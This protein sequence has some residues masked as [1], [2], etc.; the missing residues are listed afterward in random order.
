M[1]GIRCL[2]AACLT[3]LTPLT[4]LLPAADIQPIPDK[5]V[6]LTFDDSVRSHF[7]VARPILK[8][9]GFGATFFITEGFDFKTNKQDYLT[10]KQIAQL[11]RDGFEIGNHTRDHLGINDNNIDQLDEQLTAINKQCRLHGITPPVSFAYPGNSITTQALPILAKH[12]FR[13]ARRG[14]T[15]EYPYRAGRGSAY[16]PGLDHP[17]LIPTAGDARPDWTLEDFQRA[18]EQAQFGRIAVLQF[19]GVP[20][21]SHPWV[22]TSRQKFESYMKYLALNKYQVI[23]LRDLEKYVPGG[24]LPRNPLGA[25]EDR[26]KM[27]ATSKSRLVFRTPP[28]EAERKYWLDNMVRYHQFSVAEIRTATGLSNATIQKSLA[29]WD[30]DPG[31]KPADLHAGSLRALPYPGG[32]HPRIGFRDGAIRPHRES[33]ISAF[34]P[35]ANGG[36][37]VVDIPEAIWS[38]PR[39]SRELLYLAHTHVPTRWDKQGIDLQPLE[40]TRHGDGSYSVTRT[41]PNQVKFGARVKPTRTALQMELW[42][43][44]GSDETLTGLVVQNC[45]MLK[46]SPDF[47][48]LTTENNLLSSP[49]AACRNAT[50]DRWVIT[51]WQHCVRPWGNSTC[52]CL[53]SDPQFPD[54]QPGQTQRLKG[55]LSFYEGT[56]IE[57]EFKRIRQLGWLTKP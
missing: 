27:L 31:V 5:L 15:P 2:W 55:W 49:F 17:L 11:H 29:Q 20:D 26:T 22:H 18:V 46:S 3:F 35:W 12:G 34:P 56:R 16:E 21:R 41:L 38:R 32:R 39:P 8:Q 52:P 4:A 43:T 51:A 48:Q 42:I 28:N 33:K 54:C 53:H 14:G 9:Y 45:V 24:A 13:F 7:D 6:V 23:A 50:G 44:N 30:L 37:V 19:H 25:I 40:W 1:S 10:W 57:E 36:Y 47:S